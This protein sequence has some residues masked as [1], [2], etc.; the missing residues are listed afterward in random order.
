MVAAEAGRAREEAEA[1]AAALADELRSLREH[2]A[3]LEGLQEQVG[4]SQVLG[5][6]S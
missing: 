4:E 1:R 6:L 3:R 5:P 2:A